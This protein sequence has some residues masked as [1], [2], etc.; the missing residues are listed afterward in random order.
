MNVLAHEIRLQPAAKTIVKQGHVLWKINLT[1]L[2][3]EEKPEFYS[4]YN[5]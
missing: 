3:D 4:F 1:K 5:E 2:F